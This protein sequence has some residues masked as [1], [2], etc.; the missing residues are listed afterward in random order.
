MI[1]P[2]GFYGIL[3]LFS[4]ITFLKHEKIFVYVLKGECVFRLKKTCKYLEVERVWQ[5]V[6]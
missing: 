4:V 6:K 1:H 2:T 5:L 3:V